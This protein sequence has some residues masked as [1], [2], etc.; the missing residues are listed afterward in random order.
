MLAQNYGNHYPPMQRNLPDMI[1]LTLHAGSLWYHGCLMHAVDTLP[2][3]KAEGTGFKLNWPYPFMVIL[4]QN[5]MTNH[6][7]FS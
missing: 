7:V 4:Q 3:L 2:Y 6:A 5:L 1:W